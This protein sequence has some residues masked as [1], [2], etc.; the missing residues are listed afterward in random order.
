MLAAVVVVPLAPIVNDVG[1]VVPPTIALNATVPPVPGLTASAKA[2][3]T[4]ELN[5]I[6]RP[7]AVDAIVDEPVR[8][9][10]LAF[11]VPKVTLPALLIVA[12]LRITLLL[13]LEAVFPAAI[14]AVPLKV[15]VPALDA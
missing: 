2:P 4:V 7:L 3:F 15:K 10:V 11:V 5:V 6:V 8:T 14:V 9:T 1:G 13:K 12:L